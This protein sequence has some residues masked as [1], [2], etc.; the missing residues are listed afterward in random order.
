MTPPR[1]LEF[2]P[3]EL[4]G[5]VVSRFK[6]VAAAVPQRVAITDRDTTWTFEELDSRTDHLAQTIIQRVSP[7]KGCIAYLV[8]HSAEM[9]GCALAILK[10]GKVYL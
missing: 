2:D 4:D 3:A 5:S 8:D 6:K 7:G 9:I 1:T 10:S